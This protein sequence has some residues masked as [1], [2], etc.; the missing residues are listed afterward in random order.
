MD[1]LEKNQLH[2]GEGL[3]QKKK[4][5]IPWSMLYIAATIVAVLLFG[6]F[7][8]KFG[9]VFRTIGNLTPGFLT[10]AIL[11]ILVYFLF[12]G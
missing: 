7:N 5:K 1:R 2:E 4:R 11:I 8:R 6:V 3:P 10:L 9:D 12:E